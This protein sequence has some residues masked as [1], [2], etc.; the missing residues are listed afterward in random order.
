[1]AD[2]RILLDD[3]QM[4]QFAQAVAD[5]LPIFRIYSTPEAFAK[6]WMLGGC[7][8][9][10]SD[11]PGVYAVLI[12]RSR[13]RLFHVGETDEGAFGWIREISDPMEMEGSIIGRIDS[14]DPAAVAKA[15]MDRFLADPDAGSELVRE[16]S[17]HPPDRRPDSSD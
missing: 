11:A 12:Y 2:S 15:I 5:E 13:I 16:E 14:L 6:R 8:P 4:A 17:L 1:M 3:E 9:D 10:G 7:L